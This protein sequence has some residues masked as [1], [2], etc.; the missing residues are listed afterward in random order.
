MHFKLIIV[1]IEDTQT[2]R[3]MEAA[4]RAGA[5]GATVINNARGEGIRRRKT[6]LGLELE[7]QRDVL[8]LVVEEHLCRHILETIDRVAKLDAHSGQGIAFQL[9]IEDVVGVNH[10]I[11]ALAKKVEDKL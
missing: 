1:F 6:F 10:Q 2:D 3:V 8:M 4:R 9:D 7:T 11:E 5:T